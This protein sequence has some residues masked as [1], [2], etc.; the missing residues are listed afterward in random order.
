MEDFSRR[1]HEYKKEVAH[2]K[3]SLAKMTADRNKYRSTLEE[4]LKILEEKV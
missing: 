4:K 2:Y 1:E 3:T